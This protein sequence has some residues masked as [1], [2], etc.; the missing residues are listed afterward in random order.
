[1]FTGMPSTNVARSVPWSRLKPRSRYWFAFPSPEW[2][3]TVRPGI[4]S[5]SWPVRYTGRIC[6]SCRVIAP[7]LEVAA[8]PRRLRVDAVTTTPSTTVGWGAAG[9]APAVRTAA[10]V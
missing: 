4:V 6:S 10:E 5:S 2:E 1:M 9:C 7:W 8:I 3:V